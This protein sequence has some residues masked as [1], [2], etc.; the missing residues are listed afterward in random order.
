MSIAVVDLYDILCGQ[1]KTFAQHPG[2]VVYHCHI[3]ANAAA[4]AA[5][6]TR[7]DRMRITKGIVAELQTPDPLLLHGRRRFL[8]AV[9]PSVSPPP[10]LAAADAAA[11]GTP[12]RRGGGGN[13]F[14]ELSPAAV[15]DK[16][17]HALRFAARSLT[18]AASISAF[19]VVPGRRGGTAADGR[20]LLPVRI[21]TTTHPASGGADDDDFVN[22]ILRAALPRDATGLPN[23]WPGPRP[24][25]LR[26]GDDVEIDVLLL[27]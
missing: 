27:D 12:A 8:K 19:A 23:D 6:A 4:Y 17:S 10:A 9:P 2:N 15:R 14:A 7:G 25:V 20:R 22:E 21:G 16:V 26:E 13:G 5:A 1:D 18:A 11:G 24:A 3:H